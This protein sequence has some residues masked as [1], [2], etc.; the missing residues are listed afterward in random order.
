MIQKGWEGDEP[1][2]LLLRA[3]RP[4]SV[5]KAGYVKRGVREVL[6]PWNRLLDDCLMISGVGDGGRGKG[7]GGTERYIIEI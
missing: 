6:Q 4:P 2:M 7:R 1:R 5:R 3:P